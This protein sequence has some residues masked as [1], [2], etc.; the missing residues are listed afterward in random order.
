MKRPVCTAPQFPNR[1]SQSQNRKGVRRSALGFPPLPVAGAGARYFSVRSNR[2]ILWT[3]AGGD[4]GLRK[5]RERRGGREGGFGGWGVEGGIGWRVGLGE[6]GMG[7][8]EWEGGI[9]ER[10]GL[11]A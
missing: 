3:Q 11:G 1:S 8:L 6:E 2:P 9:G 10:H 4:G 7:G 5:S